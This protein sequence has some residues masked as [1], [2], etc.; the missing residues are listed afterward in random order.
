MKFAMTERHDFF[1]GKKMF[2]IMKILH[3]MLDLVTKIKV[4]KSSSGR[5]RP[6]HVFYGSPELL[7]HLHILFNGLMQH[8]YVPI[9][10]LK[11]VI[12]PIVKDNQGDLSCS[13][14]YRGITLSCLPAKL[15]E[16]AIQMKTSHL[17]H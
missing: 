2:I 5:C 9:D 4:G 13:A 8:G 16:F 3:F 10:F 7:C 15:F 17:L 6:E 12:T 1:S 14:N 11:G